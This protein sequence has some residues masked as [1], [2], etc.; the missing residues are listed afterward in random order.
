MEMARNGW[1]WLK[2]MDMALLKM[3]ESCW[4]GCKLLRI[5]GNGQNDMIV[6]D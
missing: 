3:A 4:N 2:L 5:A 1:K 6:N